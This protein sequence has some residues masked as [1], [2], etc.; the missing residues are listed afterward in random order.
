[1]DVVFLQESRVDAQLDRLVARVRQRR[2]ARLLHHV[3]ELSGQRDPALALH[4]GGLD[5]E[6]VASRLRPGQAGGHAGQLGT[7]RRL[8]VVLLGSEDDFQV[9]RRDGALGTATFG[10]IHRHRAAHVRDG[11]LQVAD[12]RLARVAADDLRQRLVGQLDVVHREPVLPHLLGDE[13]VLGDVEL[14]VEGVPR[15]LDHLFRLQPLHSGALTVDWGLGVALKSG[16][17]GLPRRR[18]GKSVAIRHFDLRQTL[19]VHDLVFLD[20]VVLVQQEGGEGVHL[21]GAQ[22]PFFPQ[23]HAAIDV[24]PYRRRER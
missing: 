22:R 17:P 18:E 15:Q 21:I 13:V 23:R 10:Y 12:A 7:L 11:A 5:E 19:G 20:D 1:M 14:L 9:F 6:Q 3:A 8:R 16:L 2:L 4:A 24:I